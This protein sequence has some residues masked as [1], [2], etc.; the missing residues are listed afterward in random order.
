M[1][2]NAVLASAQAND[3]TA[4]LE[5][6]RNTYSKLRNAEIHAV[7]QMETTAPDFEQSLRLKLLIA[8][9]GDGKLRIDQR[10]SGGFLKIFDGN[11]TWTYHRQLKQYIKSAI[12]QDLIA[13][14]TESP[15]AQLAPPDPGRFSE[16][17]TLPE[18]TLMVDG[19][20]H[21]CHVL[22][23]KEKVGTPPNT[24]QE[25]SRLWIDKETGLILKRSTAHHLRE[26]PPS[27]GPADMRMSLAIESLRLNYSPAADLFVFTP[28]VGSR[29][30]DA[31][32]FPGMKKSELTG[33]AAPPFTLPD[34]AGKDV[35][36]ASLRGK[37]VLLNFWTTW[38]APCRVEIPVLQ[39]LHDEDKSVT[40]IAVNVGEDVGL[41]RTFV[42]DNKITYPVLVAGRD[43]MAEDYGAKGFPTTVIIDKSG[44]VRTYKVGFGSGGDKELR[45]ALQESASVPAQTQSQTGPS[46]GPVYNVGPGVSPPQIISKREPEYTEE[47]RRERISGSVLLAAIISTEG[48]PSAVSV[49]RSLGGGLSDR[50]VEAVK[51]WRFRPGMKDGK[52]VA[53]KVTVEVHFRLMHEPNM[54][55]PMPAPVPTPVRTKP[56]SAEEAYRQGVGLARE[57]KLDEATAMFAEAIA[58]KPDWPQ[59]WVARARVASQQKRYVA[60]VRD[61]DEAIRRDPT[62]AA[63]YDARGLAY[64][65]SGQHERAIGNYNRAIELNPHGPPSFYNNRGWALNETGHPEK[66]M[67]DLTRALSMEPGYQVAYENR[68]L[69]AF[70]LKQYAQAIAD[71]SA[72]S[73]ISPTKWQYERRAEAKRARGDQAGAEEDLL[74]AADFPA[75]QPPR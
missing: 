21:A 39:K 40:V 47:A 58:M 38:C 1:A 17:R 43:G 15:A 45:A 63:W 2:A 70:K 25:P 18:E 35:T 4:I 33:K 36:L 13:A 9:A 56:Q 65:N 11:N 14:L 74:K 32:E 55:S 24:E 75:E 30:V 69:A 66:A 42:E 53:V 61:L 27:G 72:A 37:T 57:R 64:S 3:P 46:E 71:Y 29:L 59:A 5:R 16:V 54:R 60:A 52:A 7:N 49:R 62:N 31:P 68:A 19:I 20:A 28:P 44:I 41:V 50:A 48:I 67:S 73:Q 8:V 23:L 34:L 12:S 22:E 10:G 6:S 51:T 26:Y